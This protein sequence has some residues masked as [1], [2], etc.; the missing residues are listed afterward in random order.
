MEELGE[1]LRNLEG[2]ATPQDDQQSQLAWTL[3]S[4]SLNHRPRSKRGMDLVSSPIFGFAAD[5]QL[6]LPV[7]PPTTEAGTYPLCC[8]PVDPVP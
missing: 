4:Q 6:S 3:G 1:G 7:G 5:L 2:T 8:L